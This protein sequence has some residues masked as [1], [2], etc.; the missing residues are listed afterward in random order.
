VKV[1][2]AVY[3]AAGTE[4]QA[5]KST[6]N[7][8]GTFFLVPKPGTVYS[9]KWKDAQ[10]VQHTTTLAPVK[11]SGVSLSVTIS[12][13][14]RIVTVTRTGDAATQ[15][16]QLHLVGTMFQNKVFSTRADLSVKMSDSKVI[17]TV[18]LPTGILTITVFD[19]ANN[20]IAE[21]I[22][23]IKNEG[24]SFQPQ[25][26]VLRYGLNKRAKNEWELTVPDSLATSLSVA[27]TDAAINTDSSENIYSHLLLTSDIKGQVY[28]PAAYFLNNADSTS[29][30]LDL[31]MLTNGWRRFKWEDVLRGKPVAIKQPRDSSYLSFSGKLYGIQ[32][33]RVG[34][35]N[36]IVIVKTKDSAASQ[37]M[38]VPIKAN[39]YFDQPDFVFFDTLQVYYQFKKGSLLSNASVRFMEDRLGALALK[40]SYL[41]PA[42]ASFSDTTGLHYHLATAREKREMKDFLSA[43][44]LSAVTVRSRVKSRIEELDKRYASGLFS[45]ADSYQFD[46]TDDISA[47]GATNIFQYL[48]GKVAGLQINNSGGTPSMQWRGGTPSVYLNEM[49]TDVS[50]ISSVAVADV[51]YIKVFRPPFMGGFN[52]AGGAIAIYTKKGGDTK[53]TSKGLDNTTITGYTPIRQFYSPNYGTFDPR[54]EQR[55]LRTTLYWNPFITTAGKQNS[56]KL[57][58]YNNDVTKA[59]RVIIEGITKEG[60]LTHFETIIE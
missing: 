5:F 42:G 40:Q 4:I 29:Q 22:T 15:L 57:T 23:F 32:P 2:G 43:K 54:H 11:P 7:G 3:D 20:A 36:L 26:S 52:G 48:Q 35:E 47:L 18:A 33:G 17:P 25:L 9:A 56:V 34:N 38:M 12:G 49:P 24:Y 6:H 16:N 60:Q 58:F 14:K 55:D 1:S 50:M 45:G 19:G 37:M 46:L 13:S 31:V 53:T 8:M 27:V 30:Q 39:G 59:F 21:R 44:T 10:G 51:A 28:K 41:T